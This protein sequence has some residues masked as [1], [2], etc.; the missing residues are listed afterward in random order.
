MRKR[1]KGSEWLKF[2]IEALEVAFEKKGK[3]R[4]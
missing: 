2:D 4:E 3:V 1:K